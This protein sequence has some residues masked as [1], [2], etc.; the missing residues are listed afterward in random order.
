MFSIRSASHLCVKYS[1]LILQDNRDELRSVC[2]C[3]CVWVIG[4]ARLDVSE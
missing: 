4:Y 2:V 1:R 3:V